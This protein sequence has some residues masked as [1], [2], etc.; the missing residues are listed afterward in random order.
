LQQEAVLERSV[1]RLKFKGFRSK[2]V[3]RTRNELLE[4]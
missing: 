3:W 2:N 1:L 4:V